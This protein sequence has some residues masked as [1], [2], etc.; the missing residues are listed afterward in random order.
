MSARLIG[1]RIKAKRETLGFNQEAVTHLL[2]FSDRQTLSAI[3]TGERRVLAEE[4]LRFSEVLAA[5]LDYF[6]DPFLLVGEGC[7][8]WRQNGVSAAKLDAYEQEAGRFIALFRAL[9]GVMG[10]RPPLLRRML[11]ITRVSSYEDAMAAGER[12][13]EE[14]ALGEAPARRLA[15]VMEHELSILVLMV[16][17][18]AGVSGAACRLPELDAVLINR[19]ETPGRRHYDLAHELFHILT[20]DSMP[21]DRLEDA[22]AAPHGRIEQLADNFASALLMPRA[23]LTR[24]GAWEGVEGKMLAAQLNAAAE[25]LGVTSSALRWRLAGT[26]LMTKAVA[27]SVDEA[28]L[29][30]NGW[31]EQRIDEATLRADL[32][33]VHVVTTGR[34]RAAALVRDGFLAF[35]DAFLDAWR[36][37]ALVSHSC[38]H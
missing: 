3:E 32:K 7:F 36:A 28:L 6:T 34:E 16:D 4:L 38:A 11:A 12:F 15:A 33:T 25:E 35:L 27:R 8:S 19:R 1:A 10:R 26:G 9:S 29:R 21:P 18:V 30:N 31:K 24:F 37:G 5:P 13:A 22:A 17:A 2:G 14:L 23:A 20:W